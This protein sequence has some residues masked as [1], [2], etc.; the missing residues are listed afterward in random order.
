LAY[1]AAL[2]LIAAV[3]GINVLARL[4]LRGRIR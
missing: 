2:V 3:L 1:A 4:V